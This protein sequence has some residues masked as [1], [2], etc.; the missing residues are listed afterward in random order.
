MTTLVPLDRAI[1]E[2]GDFL[3]KTAGVQLCSARS[4]WRLTLD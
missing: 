2:F 3:A 1:P 4:E